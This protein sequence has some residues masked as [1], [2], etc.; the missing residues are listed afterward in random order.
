MLR[1][2]AAVSCCGFVLRFR[3][4]VPH[5]GFVL[6]FR[7]AVS[8]LRFLVKG[9]VRGKGQW[10]VVA[11]PPSRRVAAPSGRRTAVE[12]SSRR[13]A[14]SLSGRCVVVEPPRVAAKPCRVELCCEEW[15]GERDGGLHCAIA[16]PS[17]R[18]AA[19]PPSCCASVSS[20][21]ASVEPPHRRRAASRG[22]AVCCVVLW[23][24]V[25]WC[26]VVWCVMC[27]VRCSAACKRRLSCTCGTGGCDEG[28]TVVSAR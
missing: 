10:C 3:V 16:A 19:V 27:V 13:A 5:C 8:F 2:R 24:G 17:I 11:A 1:L 4:A 25:V 22:G 6:R 7:A 20:R 9:G 14:A 23:C 28:E 18:R 15:G 26:G 12:P 21:R